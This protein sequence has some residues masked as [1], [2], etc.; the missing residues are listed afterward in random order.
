MNE[1]DAR[2][3]PQGSHRI[4]VAMGDPR[5]A[6]GPLSLAIGNFDGVHLG[7]RALIRS[8]I[9]RAAALGA[10]PA[11]LTFEPHPRK[12]F[13]PEAPFFRLTPPD[14]QSERLAETGIARIVAVAFDAAFAALSAEQFVRDGLIG[15]LDARAVIVGEDFHFGAKRQGTPEFLREAGLRHG[16]E[17]VFV[18]PVRDRDGTVVSSSS[19]REALASGDVATANRRL[20]HPFTLR[21]EVIHGRKEGRQLGYPTANIALPPGCGLATGIYAVAVKLDGIWRP[22]VASYGRRPMFDNGALLFE[23]HVFDF[24]GDLYGRPL[25]LRLHG[26]LRPER[27]FPDLDALIRQ[28]DSDSADARRLLAEDHAATPFT[29][30]SRVL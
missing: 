10:T 30:E 11:L 26:W 13:Q 15:W 28:M 14:L 24:S 5:A 1:Q 19:I 18:P 16:F 12:F 9:E 7:H 17:T 22:G 6:S 23:T 20:G 29:G 21:G 4:E 2:N 25:D 3:L 8:T 27:A